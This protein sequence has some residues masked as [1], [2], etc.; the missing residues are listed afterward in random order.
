MNI[1]QT[2]NAI[3]PVVSPLTQQVLV[4]WW[5]SSLT[6]AQ[7]LMRYGGIQRAGVVRELEALGVLIWVNGM[8]EFVCLSF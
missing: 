3:L 8:P 6:F 2:I 7:M 5:S 1:I 4:E